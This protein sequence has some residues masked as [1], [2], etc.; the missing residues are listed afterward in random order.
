[1]I[2]AEHHQRV[3]IVENARV[4]RKFLTRLVDPLVHRDGMSRQLADQLLKAEQRQMKQFERASDALQERL[5]SVLRRL[6]R[7]PGHPAHFAD[8][9]E[10]IIHLHDVAARLPRVAPGPVD[11]EA[12]LAGRVRTRHRDLVVCPW[13]AL[14][15]HDR[16]SA[17]P[18][19]RNRRALI[20]GRKKYAPPRIVVNAGRPLCRLRMGRL[21]IVISN[22]PSWLPTIGSRSLSRSLNFGSL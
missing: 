16:C 11:A 15:S 21:G 18:L 7:G 13:A 12:P 8:G 5:G 3:R 4:D 1:M 22:V 6:I 9:G 14:R 17:W 2:E 10:A 20:P 19:A